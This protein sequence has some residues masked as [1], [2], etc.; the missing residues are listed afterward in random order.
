[1]NSGGRS[2][3]DQLEIFQQ[4][5]GGSIPTS[6]LHIQKIGHDHAKRFVEKWHY[7]KRMPTGKNICYGLML[8][9]CL[10]AVIVY[11]IGVNPY[12]ARFLDCEKV[13]E[14]KRLCRTEPRKKYQLSRF[15]SITA[16]W[17]KKEM[18]Y[19]K[20]VAFADPEH[21][22]EGTIYKASGFEKVGTTNPE[23]HLIDVDGNV[24]HRRYAFRYARRN[25][26]SVAEARDMLGVDRVKTLPKNRWCR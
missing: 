19:D 3:A 25:G 20:L 14:I 12:Q 5:D 10:Y 11:G 22:H 13:M 4:A 17:A 6:P 21:G 16:K 24:R 9:D 23:Y 7:S 1:M 26:V 15:I 8:D 18:H 2:V